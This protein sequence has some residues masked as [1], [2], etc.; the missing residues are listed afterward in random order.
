MVQ[1]GTPKDKNNYLQVIAPLSTKMQ[2][3]GLIPDYIDSQCVYFKKTQ[4]SIKIYN[5]IMEGSN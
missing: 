1:R 4:Q 2:E 3:Y 5:I